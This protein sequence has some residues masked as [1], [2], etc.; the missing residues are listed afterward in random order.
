[1][2]LSA[3]GINTARFIYEGAGAGIFAVIVEDDPYSVEVLGQYLQF[4]GV[5]YQAVADGTNILEKLKGFAKIDIIF[6]DLELT[7]QSGYGVL[8][9]IRSEAAWDAVP[10]VAYTSHIHDKYLAQQAGFHS[11]LG[12]PLKSDVFPSQLNAILNNE[13][14]W[15]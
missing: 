9:A 5:Q 15:D 14:I 8:R 3:L 2:R 4:S 11:F 10:V 12:K 13:R 6:V 7:G 1:M